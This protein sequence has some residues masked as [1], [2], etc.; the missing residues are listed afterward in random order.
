[1]RRP[2]SYS[3]TALLLLLAISLSFGTPRITAAESDLSPLL[4]AKQTNQKAL[5]IVK[6]IRH[7]VNP[8][9]TRVVVDLSQP[10]S[11]KVTRH[12]SSQT[13]R[14]KLEKARL[15]RSLKQR[16]V[17]D[18]SGPL[19]KRIGVKQKGKGTV[20]ITLSYKGLAVH[21]YHVLDRPD[22]LIIDLYPG[23][24][25]TTPRPRPSF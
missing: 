15:K 5:G 6:K 21:K 22:R 18:L 8:D 23:V 13:V 1:M 10:V 7:S 17:I 14:I 25:P 24:A 11:Y 19:I 20:D 2:R 16:P 3:H 12:P 9:R 4:L